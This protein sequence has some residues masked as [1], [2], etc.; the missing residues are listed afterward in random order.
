MTP[1][2]TAVNFFEGDVIM[3]ECTGPYATFPD[4]TT[5][6]R[7]YT[8]LA[9]QTWS[10]VSGY[11]KYCRDPDVINSYSITIPS[12]LPNGYIWNDTVVHEC[13]PDAYFSD[14]TKGPRTYTCQLNKQ[15]S[16][17]DGRC[18]CKAILH[19]VMF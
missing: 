16:N 1:N 11:C 8:C 3:H 7:N 17:T 15:W 9:N 12:D 19:F 2:N 5:T 13:A 14:G 18:T 10:G 4:N 6:V